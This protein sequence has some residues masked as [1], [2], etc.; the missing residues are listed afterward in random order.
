[1]INEWNYEWKNTLIC[2]EI[3]Q[4][5]YMCV[6]GKVLSNKGFPFFTRCTLIWFFF[7][8]KKRF[9]NKEKMYHTYKKCCND[10]SKI[11]M[12]YIYLLGIM[13]PY[14]YMYMYKKMAIELLIILVVFFFI[15]G[16]GIKGALAAIFPTFFG[17]IKGLQFQKWQSTVLI[18]WIIVIIW[19]TFG[20]CI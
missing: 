17:S 6:N 20:K 4:K 7:F 5:F 1:M 3:L 12:F 18:F 16:E 8:L 15:W 11:S 19:L 9:L 2:F 13:I 10:I 14:C